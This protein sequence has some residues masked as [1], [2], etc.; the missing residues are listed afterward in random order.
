MQG[1]GTMEEPSSI[2]ILKGFPYSKRK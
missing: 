2:G 1:K